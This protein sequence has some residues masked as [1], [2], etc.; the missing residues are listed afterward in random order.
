VSDSAKAIAPRS[1]ENLRRVG[2][3][4]AL[5]APRFWLGARCNLQSEAWRPWR[6]GCV[7]EGEW[8]RGQRTHQIIIMLLREIRSSAGEGRGGARGRF[9]GRID[10]ARSSSWRGLHR[11]GPR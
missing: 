9:G 2:P 1:P 7:W 3:R 6:H 10:C 5:S 8:R 4:R 11:R